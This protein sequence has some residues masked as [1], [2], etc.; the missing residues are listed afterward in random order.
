MSV[1]R[2][3]LALALLAAL[4]TAAG[5]APNRGGTPY[6]KSVAEARRASNAGRFDEAALRFDEASKNARLPRDAVFLRYEAALARARA[7]EVTRAR[8]ELLEIAR[9]KPA[10]A[11]SAQAAFKAAELGEEADA[12]RTVSEMEALM[13]E[14]PESGVAQVALH[15]LL[16]KDDA[17]G[18]PTKALERLEA[19]RPRVEGKH[20]EESVLYERARR[21]D[22]LERVE[23]AREAYVACAA[24]FPYPFGAYNDDS[25]YRA[26]QMEEKLGRP[27][28]AIAILERLLSQRETSS[29]MGSYERPRY[30]PALLFIAKLYEEKL[31]DRAKARETLHRLYSDFKTSPL[32]DD[33]LWREA[34]LWRKDGDTNAACS[35][36]STL[37]SDFP[38]SRYVPCAVE[39]CPSIT[40]P[41]TS[42]APKTC[43]AYLTRD[44]A[45]SK[46]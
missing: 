25:L 32:R 24:K 23:A 36:L 29:V 1:R 9:A 19:L 45:A 40:R 42:K 3:A 18:G 13:V 17:A 41:S 33:A 30:V 34:E 44:P 4:A 11:Y 28:E 22:Q 7:G 43:H 26:A 21:L 14:F 6:A 46:D 8:Q 5:C 10:H 12:A 16:R 37:A 39:R 31:N 2:S 35:R 38:D 20:L 15:R 27:K